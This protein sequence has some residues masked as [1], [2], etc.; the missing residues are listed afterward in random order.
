MYVSVP[1]GDIFRKQLSQS[2]RLDMDTIFSG[3]KPSVYRT[4]YFFSHKG[5]RLADFTRLPRREKS[6]IDPRRFEASASSA[7]GLGER[8]AGEL[9]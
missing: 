2:G 7:C 6:L 1:M 3:F 8:W 9:H 4:R 5:A